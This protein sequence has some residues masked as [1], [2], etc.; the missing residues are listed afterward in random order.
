M[1]LH[2]RHIH[3]QGKP[4]LGIPV[5]EALGPTEKLWPETVPGTVMKSV[6]TVRPRASECSVHR[7]AAERA[8]TPTSDMLLSLA[9]MVGA[10]R[11]LC[12]LLG[13]ALPGPAYLRERYFRER[14]GLWP[15]A[16]ILRPARGVAH[17]LRRSK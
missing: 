4:R 6:G 7:W 3:H 14:P 10:R 5:Q 15:L 1:S 17:L 16:Y 12:F 2:A 9:T 13:M 11:R 8:R